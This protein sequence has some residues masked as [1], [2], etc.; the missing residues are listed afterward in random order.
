MGIVSSA[1][2]HYEIVGNPDDADVIIGNSF[3][4]G[5]APG[6]VNGLLAAYTLNCANG[7]PIVADRTLVDAFPHRDSNVSHVVEGD[8]STASGQGLGSWAILVEAQSYMAANELKRPLMI[9]QAYHIGRVAMQFKKL[10]MQPIV[11]SGLPRNFDTESKQP[12]TRSLAMWVPRE[13]IGSIVLRAQHK[14]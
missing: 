9:A 7:R 4:T 6:D 5:T 2:G 8:I 3:G 14:L 12:W 1:F 11:P 13:I 10:G